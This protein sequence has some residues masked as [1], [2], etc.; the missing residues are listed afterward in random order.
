MRDAMTLLL[1]GL[2]LFIASHSVGVLAPA[3]RA[4][5]VAR[6]GERPWKLVYSIV[7]LVALVLIVR[8]Y[9]DAR[10]SSIALW[11]PP[12]GMRHAT[13]LLTVVGFILIAAAYVPR[14]RI[15]AA[16]GHPMTAGVALWSLGHLLGNGRREAVILFGA[17]FVWS[18]VTF[19][20][21]RARDREAG[22]TYA[23][24]TSRQDVIAVIAGILFA[25]VFALF[26]H[27]PLIGVRPFGT[28]G[29]AMAAPLALV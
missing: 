10:A 8:G 12:A 18:I 26:L 13:A 21:R 17:L 3:W 11:M 24:G 5:Q 15:K 20:V 9:G 22:T 27:G 2:V 6:M 16:L 7:S 25:L 29:A 23:A 14:T 4:R 1:A 28:V 19:A